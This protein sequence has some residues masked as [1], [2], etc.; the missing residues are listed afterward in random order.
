[1]GK[2][3]IIRMELKHC[4]GGCKHVC[5]EDM[6]RAFLWNSEHTWQE[7]KHENMPKIAIQEDIN[8]NKQ[9]RSQHRTYA[10]NKSKSCFAIFPGGGAKMDPSCGATCRE[11]CFCSGSRMERR[12]DFKMSM[13]DS[14]ATIWRWM[15]R[16]PMT[17]PLEHQKTKMWE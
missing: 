4:W 13:T 3:S 6:E 1:M 16:Q 5:S 12:R 8:V 7:K 14:S 10:H 17:E 9:V 2:L 15:K 11:V